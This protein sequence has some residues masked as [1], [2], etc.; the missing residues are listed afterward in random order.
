M[1]WIRYDAV[2]QAASGHGKTTK[3]VNHLYL[4]KMLHDNLEKYIIE[5]REAFDE[6]IPSL[7]VWANIDK[8]LGHKAV[9]RL[10]GWQISRIA[11]AVVLLLVCGAAAGIWATRSGNNAPVAKLSEVSPEYAEVEQYYSRKVNVAYNQ[12]TKMN[13]DPSVSDDIK[14]LDEVYQEL[15]AELKKA[16]LSSR[17]QIIHAMIRNYQTKLEILERI[18]ERSQPSHSTQTKKQD[19]ET[20]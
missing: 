11:A 19:Y 20:I 7:K 12:V 18:L 5:N 10:D 16:P 6:E 9:R 14:H 3:S 17:D 1:R 15:E 8:S 2:K 4:I 13:V